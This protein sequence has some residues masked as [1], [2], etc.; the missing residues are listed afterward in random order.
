MFSVECRVS[1]VL[2][3]NLSR[4][5]V[6]LRALVVRELAAGRD[7]GRLGVYDPFL[8]LRVPMIVD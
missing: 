2:H 5:V 1:L 4:F 8:E 6:P 7:F 3:R